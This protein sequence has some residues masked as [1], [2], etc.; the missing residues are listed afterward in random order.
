M[1]IVQI[2]PG[3]G[4]MYC[5]NC[6]RDNALVAELRRQGHDTIMIPLYLPMTLED[7]DQ[8][9]G[10]PIFFGGI[11]VYL[12]QKFPWLRSMPEWLH[13]KLSAPGL[14]KWAGGRAAK[15]RAADVGDLTLSMLRG[16]EGNQARELE[17]LVDWLRTQPKLD[18]ISL[19]NAL[20]V[21]L[22][23]KI[24]QGLKVP[25][26]CMLQGEDY[27]LDSLPDK[28]R[29]A[30]WEMLADRAREVDLFVAP[31]KYFADRM[32]SRL[33]IP[34]DKIQV[35]HNGMD[36]AGYKLAVPQNPPVIG[37]FARMCMEKG[38]HTLVDAF[39]ML[40]ERGKVLR[41]KL[42]VGGGMGPSDEAFVEG[43]K[44]RLASAGLANEVE[45]APNLTK[46]QKQNFF[47][48]LSILSVPA[49]F[50]EAFGLYLIEAWAAGVPT[51]QPPV[52]AFPELTEASRGGV[53]ARSASAADLAEAMESLL[54][55]EARR[56]ACARQARAAVEARF[57]SRSMADG[58]L[59]AF[60]R[61]A[62]NYAH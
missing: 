1:N 16:E 35:V 45:W 44:N 52:A 58:I 13:K 6:F 48:K 42:R 30:N 26:V 2:T 9:T 51:V 23:R 25:V 34:S 28:Y 10:T 38:L 56:L 59:K 3:A 61:A 50:G 49:I 40:R 20:L 62:N 11:N 33:K 53:I 12:E 60:Q 15:T 36:L 29:A 24:K 46:E 54:L 37:Y 7:Y 41:A 4:S 5:G 17:Q 27:F 31:T 14:L 21:G 57:S 39:I 8:S 47:T 18:V 43:L 55:D 32:S 22:T 19:S